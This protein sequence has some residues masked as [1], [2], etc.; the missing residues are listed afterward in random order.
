MGFAG[1]PDVEEFFEPH[2]S[3]SGVGHGWCSPRVILAVTAGVAGLGFAAWGLSV[4]GRPHY[5]RTLPLVF[6]PPLAE[7]TAFRIAVSSGDDDPG[8]VLAAVP[9]DGPSPESDVTFAFGR[10][11]EAL[12]G[13]PQARKETP[14]APMMLVSFRGAGSGDWATYR[15]LA[16]SA[17][18]VARWPDYARYVVRVPARFAA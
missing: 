2:K 6:D 8:R 18:Q 16:P 17:E 13:D 4:G 5:E 11:G 12:V 15:Q 9:A 7:G 1:G 14:A 10:D 3:D